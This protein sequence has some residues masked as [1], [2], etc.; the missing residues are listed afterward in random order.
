MRDPHDA[1]KRQAALDGF[2]EHDD[3]SP[4]AFSILQQVKAVLT[5]PADRAKALRG[6]DEIIGDDS[7]GSLKSRAELLNIRRALSTTHNR[8]LKAGR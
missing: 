6:L 2:G 4:E 8:L 1:I 5:A 3:I 7:S